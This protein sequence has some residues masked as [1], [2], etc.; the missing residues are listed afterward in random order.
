MDLHRALARCGGD[1]PAQDP[2][3]ALPQVLRDYAGTNEAELFAVAVE[4]F[5]ERPEELRA[6]TRS[7]TRCS[8]AT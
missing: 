5:F 7:S 8:R 4:A 1:P 2:Q 3:A 6:R